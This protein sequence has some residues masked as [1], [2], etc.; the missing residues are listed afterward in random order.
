MYFTSNHD[1]NSWYGTVFEQF[2]NAAQVFAVL[3]ATFNGM[4]LI[5][6]GQEA[7]LNKRLLFFDKD[8]IEWRQHPFT[9]LYTILLN[10]KKKNKAL[11]NG[12]NGGAFQRVKTTNDASVFA[13]VRERENDKI[14]AVLNL[15]GQ[16]RSVT[17]AGTLYLDDYS[18]AFT[19]EV[20]VLS[21]GAEITLPAWGYKVYEKAGEITGIDDDELP[22][23]FALGQNYP[24]PFNPVTTI[25]YVLPMPSGIAL[26]VSDLLGREVRVLAS[27]TK[28]AGTYEVIFNATGLPSGVYFYRLKAG[29]Y[30]ETKSLV[31]L[32]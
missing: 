7:G 31:L 29:T 26:T 14:F 10:L 19:N 28:R 17:L 2:G 12:E 21:E 15:S 13:F 8:Q 30:M 20:I 16:E 5:Y 6:S 4:P 9:D 23:G 11:W 27:G 22:A 18:N 32:R 25:S 1:E 24:N 3:T